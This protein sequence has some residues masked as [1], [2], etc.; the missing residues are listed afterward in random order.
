MTTVRTDWPEGPPARFAFDLFPPQLDRLEGCLVSAM[1]VLPALAEV[2]FQSVVNGPT[3]WTGDSLARCGRTRMPGYYDFNCLTYGIAQS[4]ALS[5]YLCHIITE[6]EQPYD[7][8]AE[9]DPLRYGS[10]ATPE[11]TAAKVLE[12]YSHNNQVSYPFENRPAGRDV[13]AKSAAHKA[14]HEAFVRRGALTTFSNA[15]VETPLVFLPPAANGAPPTINAKTFASHVWAPYADAEAQHLLTGVGVGHASFSKFRVSS[16]MSDAASR[17][18]ERVTT[19]TLPKRAGRTRLTYAPTFAGKLLAEF[20]VTRRGVEGDGSHDFY[21]CASRDYQRHDLAW[22]EQQVRLLESAQLIRPGAIELTNLT[23]AIEI[24]HVVGPSAPALIS[25]LCPAAAEIPFLQMRSVEVCGL[26]ADVFRISFTGEAGYELHVAAEHAA[27]LFEA[28]LSHPSA[29]QLNCRPF[30]NAAVNSLRIEKGFKVKG[31]LDFA[32]WRE[33][34]VD[35]FIPP[36]RKNELLPFIGKDAPPPAGSA[37]RIA[38]IFAVA[39]DASHAWSV[40]GDTPIRDADGAVVGFTTTSA[41]GAITG[42]TI[43][44]GY[45]Q[46]G[47]NGAPLARA[48]DGGLSLE[49]F[50]KRWA[51]DLLERPPV[52]VAGKPTT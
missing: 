3:I 8:A 35:A 9:F 49:C 29:R 20:T 31:D 47:T 13:I 4:L 44:L 24:L 23:D 52:D 48:G 6:G 28:I 50:G 42:K 45:I 21:L 19:N 25:A 10:W 16:G 26:P 34:G 17:L 40:A 30:G 32:H 39:T 1:K 33:A 7:M 14:L 18:L 43:A 37:G 11:Y 15:G 27:P 41:R 51:V 38:A 5:E 2:G 36:V 22:L 46:R 12:T